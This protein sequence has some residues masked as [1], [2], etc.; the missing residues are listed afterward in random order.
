MKTFN[1][2]NYILNY[3]D[4]KKAGIDN[5]QKAWVHYQRYGRYENRTDAPKN[6]YIVLYDRPDRLGANIT[7]YI[8][9]I[10][11]AHFNG[12]GIRLTK[13]YNYSDSPFV[14]YLFQWIH[15]NSFPGHSKIEY[16]NTSDY[17][18]LIGETTYTIKS[19]FISYFKQNII[20][21]FEI[22]YPIPFDITKCILV[23]LRLGDVRDSPDYDGSIC[24]QFYANLVENGENCLYSRPNDGNRQAP[25]STIKIKRI[26]AEL[27]EKYP[28]Y[29]VKIVTNPNET[30]DLEYPVIQSE[31]E[32]YDLYLLSKAPVV[33]LSRST[34]SLSALFFGN[35]QEVY[36]P[37]WGH[38]ACMGLNTKFDKSGF[39]YFY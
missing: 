27:L 9:Q 25:L 30:I 39:K 34:F 4:L 32:N 6:K 17:T 38:S 23:H 11:Y 36:I 28:G 33:I 14:K 12:I 13:E 20:T 31:D 10:L 7:C 35:H 29:S 37:S 16:C 19:D 21:S 1:W 18:S 15:E 2:E 3:P 8:A 26:I 5:Q 24:S 22:S